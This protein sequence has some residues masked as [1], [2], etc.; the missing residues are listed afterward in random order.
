VANWTVLAKLKFTSVASVDRVNV[1]W[2]AP[3]TVKAVGEPVVATTWVIVSE[4]EVR[5]LTNKSLYA[6]GVPELISITP[7]DGDANI[8]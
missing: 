2:A 1:V 4:F 7:D 3:V 6:P 5:F 8:T